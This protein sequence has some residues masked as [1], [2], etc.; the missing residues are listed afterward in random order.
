MSP[1]SAE[2][3]DESSS[4]LVSPSF[5]VQILASQDPLSTDDSRLEGLTPVVEY[6][7]N[8]LYKYAVGSFST[9]VQASVYKSQL[10]QMGYPDAFVVK[11]EGTNW[12]EQGVKPL[13]KN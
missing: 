11:F 2:P 5:R 6:L 10:Q 7:R 4:A 3:S 13:R 9:S 8:G 12:A 1:A